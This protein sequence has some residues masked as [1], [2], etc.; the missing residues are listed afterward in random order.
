MKWK[1]ELRILWGGGLLRMYIFIYFLFKK[2]K[3]NSLVHR[4]FYFSIP[5]NSLCILSAWYSSYCLEAYDITM[6]FYWFVVDRNFSA[7]VNSL[8][9]QLGDAD[10]WRWYW[11]SL[12]NAVSNSLG[13]QGTHTWVY[14]Y[15]LAHVRLRQ[16]IRREGGGID[17]AQGCQDDQYCYL[18]KHVSHGNSLYAKIEIVR[19][20]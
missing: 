10:H 2:N 20:Y 7:G 4:S 11:L 5:T 3:V 19:F 14:E 17:A 13:G 6:L 8:C 1:H 9:W 15:S 16:N 18:R 12:S